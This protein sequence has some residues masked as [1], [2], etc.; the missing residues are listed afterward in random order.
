MPVLIII[1]LSIVA[2]LLVIPLLIE[3]LKLLTT[4][5]IPAIMIMVAYI[6]WKKSGV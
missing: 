1:V 2:G 5:L 3:L 4:A 6:I